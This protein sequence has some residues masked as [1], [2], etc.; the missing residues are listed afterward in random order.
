M[1]T[2]MRFWLY[3]NIEHYKSI[4]SQ[5]R[6]S[7][8]Y[9]I[10][11]EKKEELG[12]LYME[13]SQDFLTSTAPSPVTY[14]PPKHLI[15]ASGYITNKDGEVF[16]VRHFH[17]SDTMEIPGG[18]L[19][20]DATI[21]EAIHREVFEEIGIKVQLIGLNGI[22]QNVTRGVTC[23]VFR[24]EYQSG[25]LR[26]AVDETSEVI[27]T[28]LNKENINQFITR[29]QFRSRTI[30]AMEENYLPYGAFKVRP[31]ELISRFEI[32]NEYS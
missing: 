13:S 29:E 32:K 20:E 12:E 2:K 15:A 1:T 16:L 27:F 17:R 31:Y 5:I 22:Y 28:K 3:R 23:V 25:E 4:E 10:A 6:I 8:Q 21:E 26:T 19:D 9:R 30:D 14:H 18:Q 11:K 7:E 24:S